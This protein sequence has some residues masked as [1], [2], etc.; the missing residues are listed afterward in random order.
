MRL[1]APHRAALVGALHST[2]GAKARWAATVRPD[3]EALRQRV[4]YE[5]G[6]QGGFHSG[7]DWAEYWGGKNPRITI[8]AGGLDEIEISGRELLGEVRLALGLARPDE[9]F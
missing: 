3:D 9:L 1:A 7:T 4:G 6:I 5:F 2:Q 8:K